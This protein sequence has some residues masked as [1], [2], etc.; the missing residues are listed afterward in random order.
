MRHSYLIVIA[1]GLFML[2]IYQPS[3]AAQFLFGFALSFVIV[4]LMDL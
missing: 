3:S 2:T 1:V 4:S